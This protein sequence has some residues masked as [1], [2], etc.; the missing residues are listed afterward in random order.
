MDTNGCQGAT[1][2]VYRE[3]EA[4]QDMPEMSIQSEKG[5][6]LMPLL[7]ERQASIPTEEDGQQSLEKGREGKTPHLFWSW[8]VAFLILLIAA[9][10]AD[11]FVL[12]PNSAW[13]VGAL[14]GMLAIEAFRAL[15]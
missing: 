13:C 10:C 4:T 7:S 12:D 15:Q 6:S 5:E 9:L 14:S 2:E 3:E 11:T 1:G 8:L